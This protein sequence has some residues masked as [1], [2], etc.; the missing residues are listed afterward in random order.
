LADSETSVAGQTVPTLA[1]KS[2]PIQLARHLGGKGIPSLL[3]LM[4]LEILS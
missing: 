3:S 2:A 4:A 1:K